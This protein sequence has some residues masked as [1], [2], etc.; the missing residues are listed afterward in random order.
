MKYIIMCGGVYE[1]V[2]KQRPFYEINNETL[3]HRTIR[4]LKEFGIN[5]IAISTDL[6]NDAFDNCGVEVLKMNNNYKCI[7]IDNNLK[8][9]KQVG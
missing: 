1:T 4:L 2:K 5:D 9:Y 3:I 7:L 8:H 6:K